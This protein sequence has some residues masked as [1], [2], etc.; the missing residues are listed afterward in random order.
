MALLSFPREHRETD[1]DAEDRTGLLQCWKVTLVP[2]SIG[3]GEMLGAVYVVLNQ[4]YNS[5]AKRV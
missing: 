5:G 2:L 1:I 3:F 4:Q